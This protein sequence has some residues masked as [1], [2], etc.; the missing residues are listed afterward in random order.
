MNRH[1][2]VF[3]FC[4]VKL[5]LIRRRFSSVGGAELYVQRLVRS[6]SDAGHELH[7]Y[8]EQWDEPPAGTRVHRVSPAPSR[9]LRAV[10]FA[11]QVDA[12]L[13]QQRFDCV[14]SF[15]RTLRQDVYRAGDGVHRAWLDQRRRFAPWYQKPF[16]RWGGFHRNMLAL[17]AKTFDPGRTGRV[18]VNSE[19]V[20]REILQFFAFPESRIHL[21]RNGIDVQRFQN[22]RRLETRKRFGFAEKDFVILFVGSGW[23]RKGLKYAMQAVDQFGVRQGLEILESEWTGEGQAPRRMAKTPVKLL[24]IGKGRIP[25]LT[26]KDFVFA[27]AM[28]DVENAYAAA[29]LFLFPPIYEPSANVVF[30]AMAAG[31]PVISSVQNGSSELIIEG[32]NGTVVKNPS[33]VARLVDAIAYWFS[34]RFMLRPVDSEQLRLERNVEETLKVLELAAADRRGR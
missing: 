3:S 10:S 21:V 22:G 17:E 8:T 31:L 25:F 2:L 1:Q 32:V 18:I 9:A 5:A 26:S 7:F 28:P 11:E 30:E 23:E 33:D 4:G 12:L 19:M 14:L 34:Q 15:E 27:G 6:L 24:V 29:D 20:R 13:Q 16:T